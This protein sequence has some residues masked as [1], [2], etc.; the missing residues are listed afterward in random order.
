MRRLFWRGFQAG[1]AVAGGAAL[2]FTLEAAAPAKAARPVATSTPARPV[3]L[4]PVPALPPA[5][6]AERATVRTAPVERHDALGHSWKAGAIMTGATRHRLIFFS[7]DDG[8]DR[9]RTPALLDRLD[10]TGVRAMFFVNANRFQGAGRAI[11]EQI[12]IAREIVRRGHYVASHTVDH[13]QLPLLD[14][15]K[16]LEQIV[17]AEDLFERVFGE[18]PWMFR[19]PGGARSPRIDNLLASRDYT[20]VLWNLGAGDFQVS[21]AEEVFT[22]WKRV[23]ERRERE[24]GERGGIVLLHDT[25]EWSVEAFQLIVNE[26][27]KRNCALYAAG[28]EL[29]DIVDEPSYF[30]E[31]RGDRPASTFAAMAEPDAALLEA[32]QARLREETSQRCA[33]DESR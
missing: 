12:A 32:R 28:E 6:M 4:G 1:A 24:F 26:L 30:F 13:L 7:F 14:D 2:A 25:H 21:S 10:A 31:A 9:R 11:D 17:G 27:L 15:A 18:R 20:T 8:P 29:Y 5:P 33:V 22:T 23:A 3:V 19:P 16:A